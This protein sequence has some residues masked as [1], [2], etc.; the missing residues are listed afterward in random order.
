[1][2]TKNLI[3]LVVAFFALNCFGQQQEPKPL[4]VLTWNVQMLPRLGA[5]FSS[6]F[7]KMQ[8]TRTEWIVEYLRQTDYDVIVL[9][10]VFDKRFKKKMEA[11]LK[12]TFPHQL[13]PHKA[14]LLKLSNGIMIFSK[15]PF[16]LVAQHTFKAAVAA[17]VFATK[18]AAMIKI[19]HE[20]VN[21]YL[22]GTH[23]QADYPFKNNAQVRK[24][25][26]QEIKKKL[27]DTYVAEDD[28]LV[29]AGD[30]NVP[31]STPEYTEML[32]ILNVNDVVATA[33]CSNFLTFSPLNFWNRQSSESSKLD[34]ILIASKK[35]QYQTAEPHI[36]VITKNYKGQSIDL[37][38][39]H[40]FGVRLKVN[41]TPNDKIVSAT[42]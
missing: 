16:Q 26:L 9:E 2:I 40:G 27:I 13:G 11:E 5:V 8:N 31:D 30:L 14:S 17:D 1:M 10:E 3:L 7:R 22:I 33:N 18:G 21:Y 41:K 35:N 37:A 29:I 25:Q 34:Y 32:N 19:K 15:L 36:N 12:S 28:V 42:P 4:K 23:L 20:S 24:K 39:H 6:S 38:D